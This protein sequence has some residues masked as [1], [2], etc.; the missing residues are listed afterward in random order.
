MAQGALSIDRRGLLREV[1]TVVRR[2]DE[3]CLIARVLAMVDRRARRQF[4]DPHVRGSH[5][6]VLDDD[7]AVAQK[8]AGDGPWARLT[9]ELAGLRDSTQWTLDGP[10]KQPCRFAIAGR[11]PAIAGLCPTTRGAHHA[12]VS[13]VIRPRWPTLVHLDR[14]DGLTGLVDVADAWHTQTRAIRRLNDTAARLEFP[15]DGAVPIH[16]HPWTSLP[17]GPE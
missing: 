2:A 6:L 1:L 4:D 10:R 12:E 17:S 16:G 14:R 7:R 13:A 5:D 9:A 15:D 8:A 11:C 3:C